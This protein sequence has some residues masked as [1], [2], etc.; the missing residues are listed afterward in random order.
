MIKSLNILPKFVASLLLIVIFFGGLAPSTVLSKDKT[1]P[2]RQE[3]GVLSIRAADGRWLP[4]VDNTLMNLMVKDKVN[5]ARWSLETD[6]RPGV[7]LHGDSELKLSS[8]PDMLKGADFIRTSA[9]SSAFSTRHPLALLRVNDDVDL[10]IALRSDIVRPDWM[11]KARWKDCGKSFKTNQGSYK[12]YK[13]PYY[14]MA[15]V[16][17]SGLGNA[18]TPMYVVIS[19]PREVSPTGWDALPGIL[20]A[21]N[22]PKFP[23]RRFA[24]TDFEA[25][26]GDGADNAQAFARAIAACTKAG[27][28]TVVVPSG[29]YI[30]RGPI[31]LEDNVRLHLEADTHIRFDGPRE[32]YYPR[33][34]TRMEGT[35]ILANSPL[36]YARGKRNI[37]ITGEG[38]TS[39]LDGGG[40]QSALASGRGGQVHHLRPAGDVNS[41]VPLDERHKLNGNGW[42]AP[43][44]IQF[45]DCHDILLENYRAQNPTGGWIHN[46]V[47]CNNVTARK[48]D[49]EGHRDGLNPEGC[50]GV[51]IED[52]T[53]KT[54]DDAFAIKAGRD[55]DAWR[56][57]VPTEN[58]VIRNCTIRSGVNPVCVGS[59]MS[60]GVRNVFVEGCWGDGKRFFQVKANHDRGGFVR[61]AYLRGLSGDNLWMSVRKDYHGYRGGNYPPF[62]AGLSFRSNRHAMDHDEHWYWHYPNLVFGPAR[63]RYDSLGPDG[64]AFVLSLV[65]RVG[66]SDALRFAEAQVADSNGAVHDAAVA[67]ILSIARQ[68]PSRSS[69][70]PEERNAAIARL[71]PNLRNAEEKRELLR[72]LP[73]TH[74]ADALDAVLR[75]LE[76]PAVRAEAEETASRMLYDFLSLRPDSVDD[77]VGILRNNGDKH[78]RHRVSEFL[79]Y[80]PHWSISEPVADVAT[81][82]ADAFISATSG[83]LRWKEYDL[84]HSEANGIAIDQALAGTDAHWQR[85]SAFAKTIIDLPEARTVRLWMQP[86]P[87]AALMVNG[88][89]VQTQKT[90][91][92]REFCR[93]EAI[94]KLRQGRNELIFKVPRGRYGWML[95][96]T[97]ETEDGMPIGSVE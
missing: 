71:V 92:K 73:E 59:E 28:G 81:D 93:R 25:A 5:A 85:H 4:L 86:R 83:T 84:K 26:T 89:F 46:P 41:W 29:R 78:T 82:G 10:F 87:D 27:G 60:A 50:N 80:L 8:L 37:A 1:L 30:L 54:G 6:L 74:S 15:Y 57:G 97:L 79:K 2:V 69:I 95:K 17:L 94:L 65:P 47:L 9:A 35:E 34:L 16:Y 58:I 42:V 51:L 21:I 18:E 75:L 91:G 40:R 61:D 63:R 68:H 31:Q 7:R 44:I 33:V 67:A 38:P 3:N 70:T 45:Y 56:I 88:Q 72:I 53:V 20:E 19:K 96:A 90:Y 48:L 32:N 49:I 77:V 43:A 13:K 22:P 11:I 39:V 14:R 64:K 12:L 52:C 24:V 36:V 76:E 55:G 66:G 23:D 62:F